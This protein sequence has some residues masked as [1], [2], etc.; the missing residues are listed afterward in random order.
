MTRSPRVFVSPSCA[1]FA[2]IRSRHSQQQQQPTA[3]PLGV[4]GGGAAPSALRRAPWLSEQP[5]AGTRVLDA[6][7]VLAETA[8]A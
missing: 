8:A 1:P 3:G 5:V 4:T 2:G 7:R 6:G